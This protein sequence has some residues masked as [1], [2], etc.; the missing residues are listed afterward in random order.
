MSD[1]PYGRV[2]R[3]TEA[4]IVAAY[5]RWSE[6]P[7]DQEWSSEPGSDAT[8]S[9]METTLAEPVSLTGP[10]TYRSKAQRTVTFRP[11]KANGWWFDRNDLPDSLPIHVSVRNVWTTARNIVLLSG[12]PTTTCA[13]WST[14]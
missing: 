14:S 7:V 1:K 13:W 2:L 11:S 12:S 6:Q 10:G 5:E 3:G 8:Y 4:D 9:P